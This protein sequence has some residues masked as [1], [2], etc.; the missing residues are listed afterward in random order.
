MATKKPGAGGPRLS[1]FGKRTNDSDSLS[2]GDMKVP[3]RYVYKLVG[4]VPRRTDVMAGGGPT[5][6]PNENSGRPDP[7]LGKKRRN[8]FSQRYYQKS[9]PHPDYAFGNTDSRR[10]IV[11]DGAESF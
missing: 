11:D 6:A 10:P 9:N 5:T 7:E 8:Q 4:G 3:D 1:S 2:P